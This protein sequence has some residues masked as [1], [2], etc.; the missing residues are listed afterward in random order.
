[1]N[2]KYVLK[3]FWDNEPVYY[4]KVE[5]I[6]FEKI[7]IVKLTTSINE[8]TKFNSIE[9][10][11]VEYNNVSNKIFKIYPVCPICGNAYSGHPAISRYDNKSKICSRCGTN[12]AL[13]VFIHNK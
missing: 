8:A 9:K 6:I 3:G 12:E 13:T 11:E 5:G 1:M 4:Q 2:T 10:A 7:P